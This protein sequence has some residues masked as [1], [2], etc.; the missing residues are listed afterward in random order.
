MIAWLRGVSRVIWRP[1]SK[2]QI[3]SAQEAADGSKFCV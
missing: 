2:A 3:I 1:L